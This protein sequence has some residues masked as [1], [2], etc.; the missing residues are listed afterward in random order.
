[1]KKL[2]FFK[3]YLVLSLAFGSQYAL[4]DYEAGV[5]A[6]FNGDFEAAFHEFSVAA[7]EGLD[8][9]QYNLGIL[10]FIG[11]GVDQDYA[12]AFKWTEA[13]ALQGHIAAQFNLGNLYYE[14]QGVKRD[15]DKTV[16]WFE[17]AAKG[18]HPDAA[19]ALAMMY[20]EGDHVRK[21]PV[22]AHAWASMAAANENAD[23]AALRGDL[24]KKMSSEQLS[25]ARRQFA[26]W[27][28][29]R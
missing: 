26:L 6:A 12:L 22:L 25:Q 21:N 9:A 10:Y 11:Q 13:A 17:K 15:R 5:N 24:E 27:Q 18:G 16:E 8:L 19:M 7:E 14:G 23:A 20:V 3:F 29:E 4:A 2:R 1:L 28:I